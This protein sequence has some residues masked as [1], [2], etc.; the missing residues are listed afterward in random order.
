MRNAT[1]DAQVE[2]TR[3]K[4]QVAYGTHIFLWYQQLKR[5]HRAEQASKAKNMVL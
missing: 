2:R 3:D 5:M 4:V 1:E